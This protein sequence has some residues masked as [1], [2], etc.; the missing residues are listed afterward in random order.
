[1]KRYAL[2][3]GIGLEL[4]GITAFSLWI[5]QK[6]EKRYPMGGLFIVICLFVGFSGW[7]VRIILSLRK[8]SD[9]P[10]KN[11]EKNLADDETK[12]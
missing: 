7:V 9:N 10:P 6:L 1:V 12:L 11:T 2:F 5:G 3:M 4:V 8:L